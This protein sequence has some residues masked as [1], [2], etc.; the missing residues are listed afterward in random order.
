[1]HAD[2][3]LTLDYRADWRAQAVLFRIGGGASA[4]AK[5]AKERRLRQL[6]W[7]GMWAVAAVL[8]LHWRVW[9]LAV[10]VGAVTI[11]LLAHSVALRKLGS[12]AA[13]RLRE[14]WR[15]AGSRAIRLEVTDQGLRE[16]DGD[17]DSFAPWQAVKSYWFHRKVLCLEL[18][19]GEVAL[20]AVATLAGGT[21]QLQS[22]LDE[23]KARGIPDRNFGASR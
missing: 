3:D 10:P 13:L 15:Q 23:L 1:M 2:T 16:F 20:I 18:A 6:V 17:V 8:A 7:A 4:L 12:K 11:L 5:E 9:L 22:L 14:A 19:N 21:S